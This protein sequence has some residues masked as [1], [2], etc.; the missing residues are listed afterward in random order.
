[1][2]STEKMLVEIY[3]SPVLNTEDLA[4]IFR[5]KSSRIVRDMIAAGA[6][7]V[8]TYKLRDTK[9]SPVVANVADVASYL[10][11]RSSKAA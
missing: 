8:K 4:R 5:F 6:F 9:Q 7:Y 1:M 11:S 2:T 10:D 3:G